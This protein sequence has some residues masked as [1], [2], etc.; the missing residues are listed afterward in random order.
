MKQAENRLKQPKRPP[1]A[2]SF[3]PGR[4]GNPGGRPKKTEEMRRV[5]EAAKLYSQDALDA[6]VDE[7]RNGSG[8][9]R[10]SAS[11][12]LLDRAWG[13][14][15]ERTEQGQPGDFRTREQLDADIIERATKLGIVQA[16]K[17]A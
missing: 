2:G 15:L 6:L 9:P 16:R 4:T 14:P 11:V 10:V 5:E 7:A 8:A 1:T 3:A 13:K 12:A 17:K